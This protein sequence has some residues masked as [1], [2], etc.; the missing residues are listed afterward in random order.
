MTE[1]PNGRRRPPAVAGA[2]E[3]WTRPQRIFFLCSLAAGL[4]WSAFIMVA[5]PGWSLDD[6][7]SHY[8]R[9]RSVWE[10]PALIFDSWTRIGRNLFHVLPAHFGLTVARLWT[11]AFAGL[12]VVFTALL[13]RRLG[14]RRAWLAP[15]ALCFQPWFP[16]LSWGVLTQTPFM[17]ALVAGILALAS[18]RLLL[19][20]LCFGTLPL[21]RHEG[22]ALTG[23]WVVLVTLHAAATGGRWR[24]TLLAVFLSAS[25]MA[26]YNIAALICLG[27]LPSR[28][29]L[30]AKP[31]EIYGHGTLWHFIPISIR[32]AG[33][34]TLVLATI[35]LP[36]LFRGWKTTWPL[37]F[38]PAY[39]ALHSFVY[40]KGLFASGGYYHFLMPAAPGLAI[41]ALLGANAL[42]DHPSRILRRTAIA[43]LA[44]LV[45]QGLLMIQ[46]WQNFT[47]PRFTLHRDPIDAALD[48]ALEWQKKARP[49]AAPV[50]CH[51]IYASFRED[52]LETPLRHR[53]D[54]TPPAELPIHAVVIWENKYSDLTG[55][56]LGTLQA[57]SAWRECETF[58]QGNVKVF[59]KI[60]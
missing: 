49:Q 24:Q 15:I 13:A 59:E 6:E 23:L 10:N 17:L 41:A 44:G 16:E 9:S 39:F 52:W 37:A 55:M 54:H 4:A 31:T 2:C 57:D 35:G 30:S 43:L 60:H 1:G 11:L 29:L 18:N 27:D 38:Y 32:P 26:A 22:I 3:D 42:L 33:I 28:V 48:A 47:S 40:W 51:H 45:L 5:S 46:L 20:G 19:S 14:I 12:A 53:L 21:I 50:V 36:A 58:G 8:L 7:L 34:F 25:P 56:P